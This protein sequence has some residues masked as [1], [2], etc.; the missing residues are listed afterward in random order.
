MQ[1]QYS[2]A[3]EAEVERI[4][5]MTLNGRNEDIWQEPLYTQSTQ[6]Y[7]KQTNT[8]HEDTIRSTSRSEQM[9]SMSRLSFSARSF[10]S[11]SEKFGT[12][13][14]SRTSTRR[15]NQDLLNTN[16]HL[17]TEPDKPFVPK[18]LKSNRTSLLNQY[19]YY[20]SAKK[21]RP[22]QAIKELDSSKFSDLRETGKG[23][24][25][26]PKPRQK[27]NLGNTLTLSSKTQY[28]NENCRRVPPLDIP[29]DEDQNE[30][31]SEQNTLA[32]KSTQVS[33]RDNLK[34]L[35]SQSAMDLPQSPMSL[36]KSQSLMIQSREAKDELDNA[37]NHRIT[38]KNL[39]RKKHMSLNS[40]QSLRSTLESNW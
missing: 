21:V 8:A 3:L 22:K 35:Q 25:P 10:V 16:A 29:A 6:D 36:N 12:R 18:I 7:I 27:S 19:K 30:F 5:Q 9:S 28:L 1:G 32:K 11:N 4:V 17:F 20:N 37:V 39:Q 34:L 33:A 38:P 40:E 2:D 26:V 13:Q 15:E 23:E 14:R 31:L 24:A